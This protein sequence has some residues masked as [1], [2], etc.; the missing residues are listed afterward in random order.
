MD[1]YL[2]FGASG[3]DGLIL[4]NKL[5]IYGISFLATTHSNKGKER[6]LAYLPDIKIQKVDVRSKE[7]VK[8][9]IK[10]YQPSHIVNLASISSV[11]QS[12]EKPKAVLESNLIGAVNILEGVRAVS[13]N[14]CRVYQASSSEMF[15]SSES[16]LSENSNFAPQ[17]PYALSKLAAHN[18]FQMYRDIHGIYACTGILFNHESPLREYKFVTRKVCKQVAEI[19]LGLRNQINMGNLDVIRDWGWAPDYVSAMRLILNASS[20]SDFV[21][22]TGI[23]HSVRDLVSTAFKVVGIDAWEKYVDIDPNL[24]R[25][26]DVFN[27]IGDSTKVRQELNWKPEV[28]FS[29]MIQIMVE[30]DL[31]L[32][33]TSNSSNVSIHIDEWKEL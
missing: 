12:W 9:I 32:L 6:L 10:Q 26:N 24:Q 33:H 31:K 16:M 23:G 13:R 20:P 8:N 11:Q 25:P 4:A 21:V 17:S 3:Q 30:H 14:T 29:Q 2:L 5:K 18:L 15:G 27:S 7:Q 19:S 28:N 1:R 22:A